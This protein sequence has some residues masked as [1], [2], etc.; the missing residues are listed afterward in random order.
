MEALARGLQQD[1]ERR[2]LRRDGQQVS[3]LL[4]LLPERRALVRA[5]TRQQQGSTGALTEASSEECR[6]REHLDHEL[7]DVFRV[8]ENGFERQLVGRLGQPQHHAVV[9]PHRFDRNV[10]L[11]HQPALDRHG[12]GRVDRSAERTENADPPVTDFVTESLDDDGSIVRDCT[13][14]L[15]LLADIGDQVARSER[16]EPVVLHHPAVG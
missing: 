15:D 1:W 3:G 4:A 6:L 16:V 7:V 12:P 14:G 11:L 2:I 13:C 10:V 5:T 9:A 8:D